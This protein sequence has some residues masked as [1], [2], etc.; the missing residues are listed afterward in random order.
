MKTK[1]KLI[2]L[3]LAAV[4]LSGCG[5]GQPGP[6]TSPSSQP[7]QPSGNSGPLIPATTAPVT[8]PIWETTAPTEETQP[9]PSLDPVTGLTCIQWSTVPQL[10][11]LGNGKVL[12]CRNDYKEGAG[13]VNQLDV[14]EVYEDRVLAQK[15]I[16]SPMELVQQRFQD[17][18]FILRDDADGSFSVYDQELQRKE[19]FSA[20]NPDG[21]F[22]YDRKEYYFVNNSVLYRMD[23]ATGNYARMTLEYDLHLESLIGIHPEWEIVVAR[24]YLSFYN[25]NYGICA[26]NCKSGKIL[27]LNKDISHLWFNGE[28][29]YAAMTNDSVY[30][31]NICFG[32]LSDG[33]QQKATSNALGSDKVSYTMLPGSDYMLL[34]TVDENALSTTVY[35]LSLYGVCSKLEQY[36][37]LTAT[38]G[39][40]YLQQEQLILGVYPQEEVFLPVI[41][42][43][44]VLKYEKSL[45]LKKEI[46][47][48]L[49]DRS[50]ILNYQSE[51]EGPDLPD[52]LDSLRQRADALEETYGISIR[53]ENQTLGLCGSYASVEADPDKISNA[54]TVLDQALALYPKGFL[55]QFQNGIGEGGLNF[56]LTGRLQGALDPVGKTTKTADRYDLVLDI[57]SEG[58]ERTVHHELW[59][60][61]EME[62]STDSFDTPRWQAANPRGFLYYGRYDSGYQSLT[63]WTYAE[64][65]NQC[66]F[67]DAYCRI[68]PREDRARLMDTVMTE[69]STELLRSPAL[70]EKLQIMS[71]AIRNHFSTKG[72]GTPYWERDL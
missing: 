17:G 67:V 21:Y 14:L 24:F 55:G 31:S 48:A 42:D 59:H 36:D 44:K 3:C 41:I 34:R 22:S 23:V 15:T 1:N 39:P 63:Q 18:C 45:S 13:V 62:L 47:P 61:I 53:M 19:K 51:A 32:T 64:S 2:A 11:S 25:E 37:Y 8:E 16:S 60:A 46:W 68:N 70:R 56:C 50:V 49:V 58:L 52:S 7:E 5:G 43:P 54:L 9:P 4:L 35:D 40:V 38:L 33:V 12:A 6:D 20:P 26:I 29:F 28:N 57:T 72:W 65:G 71:K 69:D 66:H 10:L 30:G 27:L